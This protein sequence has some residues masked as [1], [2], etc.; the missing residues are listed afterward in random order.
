MSD[1]LQ[2]GELAAA[3]DK[4]RINLPS[5]QQAAINRYAK[6]LWEWNQ[7]LNLTRH[8]DYE[9]FVARDVMDACMIAEQL[10]PGE[11]V[12]DV[13]SGGGVPGILVAIVRPDVQVS[14]C[15]SVAKRAKAL[16]EIVK[17]A[18][19]Q[20]PVYHERAERVLEDFRF[21][22]LTVRAVGSLA[23]LLKWFAPHWDSFD[24]LLLVKGP[25]WIDERGEAR[26]L[27]LMNELQ[28]RRAVA[29]AAPDT[30]A[31]SVILEIRRKSTVA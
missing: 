13:G 1:E 28:L 31:E 9:R 16:T 18:Q 7:R 4:F 23:K 12:L 3:L 6:A 19:L 2:H 10:A 26:H 5:Q 21:D 20:V 8:T 17:T 25:K 22:T 27:G 11:E 24:R 15:E 30:G 29:Y 14:L